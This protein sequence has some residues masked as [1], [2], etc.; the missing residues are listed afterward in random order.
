MQNCMRTVERLQQPEGLRK[1]DEWTANRSHLP[2]TKEV[3][4]MTMAFAQ[5]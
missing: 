3:Y 2:L 5:L 4:A 1:K